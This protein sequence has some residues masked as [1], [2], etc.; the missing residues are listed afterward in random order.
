[1]SVSGS[2]ACGCIWRRMGRAELR[3]VVGGLISFD[4]E[5]EVLALVSQE[6]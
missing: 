6:Y 5:G 4:S 1:M 2:L 3:E